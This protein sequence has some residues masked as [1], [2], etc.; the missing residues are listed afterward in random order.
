MNV[1]ITLFFWGLVICLA[2]FVFRVVCGLFLILISLII[3][4]IIALFRRS[5]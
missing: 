4:G 5:K 3:T 1:L 2:I